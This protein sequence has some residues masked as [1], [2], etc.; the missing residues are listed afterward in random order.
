V[1]EW[2]LKNNCRIAVA[3][4]TKLEYAFIAGQNFNDK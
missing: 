1:D 2:L 4:S 3:R